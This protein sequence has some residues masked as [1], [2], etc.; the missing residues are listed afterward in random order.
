MTPLRLR[1][2]KYFFFHK[3][4]NVSLRQLIS[5]FFDGSYSAK[6]KKIIERIESD[7]DFKK[8]F[9]KSFPQ[10]L[11]CPPDFPQ[12][13][14]ERV[15]VE[16]FYPE[17]WHYYEIPQ[18]KVKPDDIVVDCGAAEGLFGLLVADRCK[19]I[20]LIEPSPEFNKCL[21]KTFTGKDN[22]ELVAAA[23]SDKTGLAKMKEND[24]SSA[25]ST[26]EEGVEVKVETLDHLFYEKGIPVSYIKIDVE[27]Q[28]F[29]T[30]KGASELIKKNRPTI[31][32]TTY[33]KYEHA[34]QIEQL[35]RSLV[36]SYNILTKGIS[37]FT[38][39]PVML[40]AW[41]D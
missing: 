37:H 10:P 38:G 1:V 7:G 5:F 25:L 31:A 23:V 6:T 4:N 22:V 18:T 11:Y 33:H 24:L 15:I 8:I 16:S 2:T 39:S 13:S 17:N 36:P 29:N 3:R 40:H 14:L 21:Q 26:D 28:D 35:L 19:K 20:Y 41:I 32:V 12:K 30:L 9:F 34:E 27:G